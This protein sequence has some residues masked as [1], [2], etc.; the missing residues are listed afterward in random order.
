MKFLQK[1][2]H[3]LSYIT[4][5]TM[6]GFSIINVFQHHL[7]AALLEFILAGINVIF[8]VLA[9]EAIQIKAALNGQ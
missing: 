5:G 6:L 3:R 7:E 1:Y 4:G 8:G 9:E 2:S